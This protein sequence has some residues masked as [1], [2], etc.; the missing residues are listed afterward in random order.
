MRQTRSR[1]SWA[2]AL[3]LL[4]LFGLTLTL[5]TTGTL[6]A[7]NNGIEDAID[8]AAAAPVDGPTTAPPRQSYLMWGLKPRSRSSASSERVISEA[9]RTTSD[10]TSWVA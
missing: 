5:S 9:M 6:R 4:V 2:S 1:K 7:Q 10:P 8:N 3:L